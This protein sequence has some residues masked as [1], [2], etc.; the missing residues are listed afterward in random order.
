MRDEF[1]T[2][3]KENLRAAE[4]LIEHQLYNAAVNRAYYAAFHAAI[5]ALADQGI[6]T[7]QRGHATIQANFATELIQRRKRYPRHFR[8][9]LMD[10][11]AV[12]D[13]AD[14]KV[15]SVASRVARRQLSK[16]KEFVEAIVREV[17]P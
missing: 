3:A 6:T 15:Q 11:Q 1:L 7:G 2:K 10:L 16:A 9:Y 8:A 14:Y 4:V 17:A 12:R 13:D 5:A